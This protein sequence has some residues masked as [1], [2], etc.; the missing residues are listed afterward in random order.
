[1]MKLRKRN[2]ELVL[3]GTA[4]GAHGVSAATGD[5]VCRGAVQGPAALV[6]AGATTQGPTATLM[7]G[8][9]AAVA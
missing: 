5:S 9:A 3:R 6:L 8:A 4:A 7:W 1:M 2:V